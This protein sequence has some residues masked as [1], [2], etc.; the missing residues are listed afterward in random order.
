VRVKRGPSTISLGT[1]EAAKEIF[2]VLEKI[3]RFEPEAA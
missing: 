2:G 3:H 1:E